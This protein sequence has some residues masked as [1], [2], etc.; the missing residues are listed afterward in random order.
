MVGL[1]YLINHYVLLGADK[2]PEEITCTMTE[3]EWHKPR[4]SKIEAEPIMSTI[5]A[6]PNVKRKRKPDMCS[7]TKIES[8]PKSAEIENLMQAVKKHTPEASMSCVLTNESAFVHT[9]L[10]SVPLGSTLSHQLQSFASSEINNNENSPDL[11]ISPSCL[12]PNVVWDSE[13]NITLDQAISL[14]KKNKSPRQ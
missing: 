5:F 2:L 6:K 3:Q 11:P 4:G 1:F 10:G 7:F 13:V 9:G 8:I 12:I 14:E